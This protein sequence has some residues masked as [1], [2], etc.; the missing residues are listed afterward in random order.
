LPLVLAAVLPQGESFRAVV[1][2]VLAKIPVDDA[3]LNWRPPSL[4]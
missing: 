3:E 1:E 2:A 4:P